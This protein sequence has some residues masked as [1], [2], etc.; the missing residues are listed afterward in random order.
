MEVQLEPIRYGYLTIR[1]TPS[2]DAV[3]VLRDAV[4]TPS[5]EIPKPLVKKTP[6]EN[7]KV[8]IGTYS[9]RLVNEVLGME[10]TEVISVQEGKVIN[11]DVKLPVKN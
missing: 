1:T 2:A 8:P 9:V 7:E 10:K 4:R 6:F 11:L 5:S 3:L